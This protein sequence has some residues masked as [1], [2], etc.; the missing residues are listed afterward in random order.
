MNC[1]KFKICAV[2]DVLPLVHIVGVCVE[3]L[4]CT[5]VKFGSKFI[6]KRNHLIKKEKKK[7]HDE[8]SV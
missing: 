3:I 4:H 5:D 6:L 1:A 8:S 7:K 2:V